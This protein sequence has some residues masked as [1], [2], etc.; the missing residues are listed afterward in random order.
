M[1][2]VR[3]VADGLAQALDTLRV[4]KADPDDDAE[5]SPARQRRR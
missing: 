5:V 3:R 2:D 1:P 4:M